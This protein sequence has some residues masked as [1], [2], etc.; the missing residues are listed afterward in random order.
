[1]VL[2]GFRQVSIVLGNVFKCFISSMILFPL[3]IFY[4]PLTLSPLP[5][6]VG[7]GSKSRIKNTN[8]LS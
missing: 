8:T 1:M 4:K 6:G 5:T 7:R 3:T 2:E